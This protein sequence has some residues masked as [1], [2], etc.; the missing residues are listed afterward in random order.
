MLYFSVSLN[1]T[2]FLKHGGY[3]KMVI[4][5]LKADHEKYVIVTKKKLRVIISDPN[6]LNNL[7]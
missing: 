4:P 2:F 1:E 5:Q 6:R 7:W 3:C